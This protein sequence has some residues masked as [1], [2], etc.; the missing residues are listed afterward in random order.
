MARI[1]L[2]LTL[3][4][5]LNDQIIEVKKELKSGLLKE[6]NIAWQRNDHHHLTVYFVG[7]MEPEQISEMNEALSEINLKHFSSFIEITDISFFPNE[8]SQVLAALVKP[9]SQIISLHEEVDKI[10]VNLGL[11]TDL[12]AYKPHITLGR[13]KEK[14]RPEYQFENFEEPLKGNIK[15]ICVFESEFN[16]GKT[17]YILLRSFE[18]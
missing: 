17:D 5:D 16:K 3:E 18:F 2:A 8:N 14:K 11:G 7:E 4:K 10:V 1:F 13:F 6:S 12:K 15:K 9:S